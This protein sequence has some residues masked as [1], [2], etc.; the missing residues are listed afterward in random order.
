MA[1][2][3]DG[4]V[5]L[6]S[7]VQTTA[8]SRRAKVFGKLPPSND[9]IDWD[10]GETALGLPMITFT[11]PVSVEPTRIILG[12]DLDGVVADSMVTTNAWFEDVHTLPRAIAP[13]LVLSTIEIPVEVYNAYRRTPQSFTSWTNNDGAGIDL[14]GETL[15][16]VFAAYTGSADTL[17]VEITADGDPVVNS[18]LLFGW[19]V[20]TNTVTIE[21]VRVV[22]FATS[23]GLLIPEDEILE[24]LEFKASV[25]EKSTGK[26]QRMKLRKNPRQFFEHDYKIID[27]LVRSEID[28]S[29]AKNHHRLWAAGVWEHEVATTAAVAVGDTVIAVAN[30]DFSD[31]RVGGSAALFVEDGVYDLGGLAAVSTNSITFS[32]GVANAYPAGS[33][34]V[35]MR[36][37]SIPPSFSGVRWPV[38]MSMLSMKFEVKDNDVSLADTS[39]FSSYKS[40]V[41]FDDFNFQ[42]STAQE[43]YSRKMN[44]IDGLVG[45]RYIDSSQL[46]SRQTGVKTFMT[47]TRADS[48]AV[49]GVLHALA[50]RWKS[51]YLPTFRNDLELSQKLVSSELNLYIVWI[52]YTDNANA[53]EPKTSVRIV[54]KSGTTFERDIVSSTQSIDKTTETLVVDSNWGTDIELA[55][56]SRIYFMHKTRFDSDTI[57][58]EHRRGGRTMRTIAPTKVVLE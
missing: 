58:L 14:L 28:M 54:M 16:T 34:I 56:V 42:G 40:K 57:R 27:E 31:F 25:I 41:L 8:S 39:G 36:A 26:E 5:V 51:F 46:L 45:P 22:P 29:L 6:T 43:G 53:A 13:G 48:W 19:G 30:T 32:S 47:K 44:I 50:G 10:A 23:R 49:R 24:T 12:L 52:G 11:A 17:S 7:F 1:I 18:T 2:V 20:G 15:P 35:P 21:F 9:P 3:D 4:A 37:A 38:G 55:D 33:R